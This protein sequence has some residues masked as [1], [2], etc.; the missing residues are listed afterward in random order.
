MAAGTPS[1]CGSP[2]PG[3]STSAVT[4]RSASSDRSASGESSFSAAGMICGPGRA[5]PGR[6]VSGCYSTM[7]LRRRTASRPGH[8]GGRAGR[9]GDLA[10]A[11]RSGRDLGGIGRTGPGHRPGGDTVAGA[12]PPRRG[13]AVRAGRAG[14]TGRPARHGRRLP[15]VRPGA[16]GAARGQRPGPHPRRRRARGDRGGRGRGGGGRAEGLP[17]RGRRHAPR[18]P[19]AARGAVRIR[20]AGGRG[21]LRSA[22]VGGRRVR[23]AHRQPGQCLVQVARGA[24][25]TTPLARDEPGVLTAAGLGAAWLMIAR[26]ILDEGVDSRYDDRPIREISLVTLAVEHSDPED[27]IIA[28]YADPD[29]LAWMRANFTD[30]TRAAAPGG[31]DTHRTR[32][33][34]YGRTGRDQIAWVI[35]RLRRG[36]ASRSASITTFQPLTDTT[37]I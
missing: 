14:R 28:R 2:W 17:H 24:G 37:Y 29:R 22:P 7:A 19:D 32:P 4:P 3:R 20:V 25:V 36:P 33:F 9:R 12:E 8:R 23:A 30:H 16:P 6:P 10:G 26:K 21:R 35:D 5:G 27:G 15:P 13:Q 31:G 34:D 11:V 1:R 18:R